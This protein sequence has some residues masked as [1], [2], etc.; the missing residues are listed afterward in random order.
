MEVFEVFEEIQ[1]KYLLFRMA[2]ARLCS[3]GAARRVAEI[4]E[5]RVLTTHD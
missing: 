3:N 5:I 4:L 1:Q 2:A